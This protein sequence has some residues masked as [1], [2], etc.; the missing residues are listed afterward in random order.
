MR[1][2]MVRLLSKPVDPAKGTAWRKDLFYLP[3][4]CSNSCLCILKIGVGF[5]RRF[6]GFEPVEKPGSGVLGCR[7]SRC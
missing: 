1:V 5:P 4:P 3:G 7:S 6:E 2:G